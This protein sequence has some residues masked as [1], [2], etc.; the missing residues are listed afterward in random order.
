M[1]IHVT[2]H[3]LDSFLHT[4][5]PRL[6]CDFDQCLFDTDFA[7]A[8]MMNHAKAAVGD[9]R[10][11]EVLKALNGSGFSPERL[12]QE[13][14]LPSE[15]A[16]QYRASVIFRARLYPGIFKMLQELQQEYELIM[17]T[18]GEPSYQELKIRAIK[19]VAEMF[20]DIRIVWND[21]TKGEVIA[22]YGE[23]SGD[24]FFDDTPK[25]LLDV[26]IH[27]SWVRC[28]RFVHVASKTSVP[29]N[30]DGQLWP[31]VVDN[32]QQLTALVRKGR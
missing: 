19:G 4:M 6:F 5:K 23:R 10:A 30:G 18:Y 13:L 27:A 7:I 15:T 26:Q 8:E 29:H 16:E 2:A 17:I 31:V 28:I 14:G 24:T 1:G 21:H 20:S 11:Q 25:H 22:S 32:V 9:D 12:V 3:D